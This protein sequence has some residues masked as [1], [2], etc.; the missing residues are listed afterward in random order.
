M[1]FDVQA[2]YGLER[3]V[4]VEDFKAFDPCSPAKMRQIRKE[5]RRR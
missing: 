4:L 3:A 1:A 5:F 2:S